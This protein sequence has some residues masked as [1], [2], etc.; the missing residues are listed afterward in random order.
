MPR[1]II[2]RLRDI[3]REIQVINTSLEKLV[4]ESFFEEWSNNDQFYRALCFS[5]VIIGEAINDLPDKF[6][7]RYPAINWSEF[8]GMRNILVHKYFEIEPSVIWD[9][10]NDCELESIQKVAEQ[11]IHQFERDDMPIP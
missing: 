10:Y 3:I 9:T 7:E 6:T 8:I 11:E 2:E 1:E 5:Y 4:Y